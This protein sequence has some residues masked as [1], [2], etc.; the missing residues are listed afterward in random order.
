MRKY[1][2]HKNCVEGGVWKVEEGS[3]SGRGRLRFPLAGRLLI[4]LLLFYRELSHLSGVPGSLGV[5][6]CSP[7]PRHRSVSARQSVV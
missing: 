3:G 6:P 2:T 1:E 5:S 4:L 7:F